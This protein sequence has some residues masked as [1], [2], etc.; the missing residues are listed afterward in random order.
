MNNP[1]DRKMFRQVGMSKQPMGIL[2]SSPE[3]MTTAQKAMMSGQPIKAQNAVSVNTEPYN[4]PYTQANY[5]LSYVMPQLGLNSP[6]PTLY[7]NKPTYGGYRTDK[8][9]ARDEAKFRQNQGTQIE[10]PGII[11][12]GKT[13]AKTFK[14]EPQIIDDFAGYKKG[15]KFKFEDP[16]IE[17]EVIEKENKDKENKDKI[18][19]TNKKLN[20][21]K[22]DKKFT[23]ESSTL[24]VTAEKQKN[25][26]P[27]K[28]KKVNQ[29]NEELKIAVS[30]SDLN[31]GDPK[32]QA[33]KG[34]AWD[35]YL[36][37]YE[38]YKGRTLDLGE[39][40]DLAAKTS[41]YDP[42]NP[43]KSTKARQDAF[44][45]GLMKAGLAI[46]SGESSNTLQNVAKG[47]GFGLEAYGKD[48][49]RLTDKED[50]NRKE[51][52][53]TLREL[54]KNE[55][56]AI[57][58]EKLLAVN[59]DQKN[60]EIL[61]RAENQDKNR[62]SQ[63][64]QFQKQLELN[65]YKVTTQQHQFFETNKIN[66]ARLGLDVNKEN[67][68]NNFRS[69][70]QSQDWAKF[71]NNYALQVKNYDL[72]KEKLLESMK[73]FDVTTTVSLMPKEQKQALGAGFGKFNTETGEID[74]ANDEDKKAHDNYVK[75]L[76]L[77]AHASKSNPTDMMRKVTAIATSGNV[78]GVNFE[79]LGINSN[80]GKLDAA[81]IWNES[82]K[83]AYDKAG[84]IK[85]DTGIISILPP[86]DV[87]VLKAR[88]IIVKQFA[89]S[90]KPLASGGSFT[91]TARPK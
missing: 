41:N 15:D 31:E 36:K 91:V 44:W 67:N 62:V 73:Q 33:T 4:A 28:L 19:D 80:K 60:A 9:V 45:M 8:T 77:L 46:A 7:G 86:D 16:V 43:D 22:P 2:A 89:T 38:D 39:L 63:E 23:P 40:E 78:A 13:E 3:L 30:E 82:F 88:E 18:N 72:N 29:S 11:P 75:K 20:I 83:E 48:I 47:L 53:S 37:N 26:P 21:I 52:H 68:L 56:S 24:N 51:Y 74:F 76:T 50:E 57:A 84:Q 34:N 69:A 71:E 1:L 55:K 65:K 85:D 61:Q 27:S 58:G 6:K 32:A 81:L 5:P 64:L 25:T 54:V 17:N 66:V 35:K 10:G 90:I 49:N 70:S 87:N 59:I 79:S 12:V 14:V 42:K